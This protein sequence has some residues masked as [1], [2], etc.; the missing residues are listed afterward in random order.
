V[1]TRDINRFLWSRLKVLTA[2]HDH[3]GGAFGLSV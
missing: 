1:K 3:S 2:S